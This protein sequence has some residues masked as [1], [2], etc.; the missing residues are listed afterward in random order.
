MDPRFDLNIRQILHAPAGRNPDQVIVDGSGQAR[1]YRIFHERIARLAALLV[2]QGLGEGKTI[3]VMDWDTSRYL[4]CFF[5]IPMV[6]ATLHTVNIRLAPEQIIFTINH[7]EDDAI[8]CHEDFLPILLPLLSRVE[9]PV[10]L[11]LLAEGKPA[12]VP[13]GFIGEYE[14]LLAEQPVAFDF[15]ALPEETRATL[16]YTTGTTGDPKGVSYTHR[17]LVLHTLAL[18]ADLGTVPGKGGLKRDDV[19]MPITPLFHVHGWG[20]PYIATFLGLKQVYPG[21]YDPARLLALIRDHGVTFSHCVP[22]ILAMVIGAPEAAATDLTGWK[23]LIGGSALSEGLAGQARAHGIDVHA[24]YGMSETCPFVT[25]AD[26][27]ASQTSDDLTLRTATGRPSPL[28]EVRVVD[29]DMADVP[30]DGATTGEIVARAPWLTQGYL[31]NVSASADLWQGGW[32]HTGDVG[33][34]SPDGTLR[35]TDRLKDVIKSGGEWVSSLTLENLAS[36]VPGLIEVAAVG[37]PD[38]RW[39]ERPVLVAVMEPSDSVGTA[40]RQKISAAIERGELPKWANPDR[41]CR[42]AALPRTSVGKID[43]KRIRQMLE[44]GEIA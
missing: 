31:K 24:A 40:I 10:K 4:E 6:G 20:F 35:I 32:L 7:A 14:T 22:T 33:H 39:G 11:I 3:A 30:K 9:R 36:T 19:Y 26:M 38:S 28:V 37:V 17:Q 2:G 16:F 1:T 27:V 13:E 34:L 8:L 15:P 43:K 41:I 23:V 5:A 25:H 18:A 21:R 12:A 42:V 44:S 29:P